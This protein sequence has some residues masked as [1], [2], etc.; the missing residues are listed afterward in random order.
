MERLIL[1]S[2]AKL[3][4]TLAMLFFLIN[5]NTRAVLSIQS[6]WNDANDLI[7]NYDDS[8]IIARHEMKFFTDALAIAR[9]AS[10]LTGKRYIPIDAGRHTWPRY[11][12]V[13]APAVGDAVS[14]G[15]NGDAY[16]CGE[17]VSISA[18]MKVIKTSDGSVF[19]RR[20]ES[21]SWIKGGTWS[22]IAG[23]VSKQNPSF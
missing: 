1:I 9:S 4:R 13:L 21:G 23:H 8:I 3:N 5:A 20:R 10:E 14:Y 18:T 16:P 12:V 6:S 2:P 22:L 11:D 17:I 19:Y 15:F 7:P